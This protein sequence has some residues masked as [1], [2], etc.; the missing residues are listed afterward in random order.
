MKLDSSHPSEIIKE[1]ANWLA[2]ELLFELSIY[3]YEPQSILDTREIFKI[4]AADFTQEAIENKIDNLAPNKE[5]AF[6]S[7][8]RHN[9]KKYHIPMI[10]FQAPENKIRESISSLEKVIP[11]SIFNELVFYNSGRSCHAYSLKIISNSEW[12][13][14]MG[15]L[16]LVS[17]PHEDQIIDTR[18]IGHRLM[19]GFSSLRWSANTDQYLALP[20]KIIMHST[21][22]NIF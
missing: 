20:R 10:D 5:L 16:L 15:R 13:D 4:R 3:E 21:L 11:K 12:I 22:K 19:S 6:H 8:L 9:K 18:W 17:H 1:L 14:F 2:D 7:I